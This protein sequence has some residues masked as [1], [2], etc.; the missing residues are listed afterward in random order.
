MK[1]GFQALDSLA[2]FVSYE[3]RVL[4]EQKTILH[5]FP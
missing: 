3:L 2:V 1:A 5:L 4:G